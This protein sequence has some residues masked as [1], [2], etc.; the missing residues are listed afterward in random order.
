MGSHCNIISEFG[1]EGIQVTDA[2]KMFRTKMFDIIL[3]CCQPPV[4]DQEMS[5]NYN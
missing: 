1:R 4:W 2:T 5:Q 3:L